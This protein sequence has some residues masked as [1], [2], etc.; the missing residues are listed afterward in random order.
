MAYSLEEIERFTQLYSGNI[1]PLRVVLCSL[2]WVLYDYFETLEDEVRFIWS[3]KRC[4]GKIS[5]LF[6]RYY[7]ILLLVFDV[8]QIH[9]FAIPGITSDAVCLAM[10][11][12]IRMLGAISLWSI[13]VIMQLRVY[14]LFDCSKKVAVFNGVMFIASIIAF[15]V[16]L[17]YN[18]EGR[19]ALIASAV[20]LPLPG[21][22]A[23]NGG[24][25][26]ALWLPA[27]IYETI[28][29]AFVVYKSSRSLTLKVRLG[30]RWSLGAILVGDNML[31]FL[32]ITVLLAFNNV[33]A[34]GAAKIIPWFSYGPFHAAMGI[35]TTR[36]LMHVRKLA[37]Q[38]DAFA[39]LS[40]DDG[41]GEHGEFDGNLPRFVD[42]TPLSVTCGEV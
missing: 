4:V 2:T 18:A 36:M 41:S 14:A 38:T 3:Q 5:Y 22:P 32:G 15:L 21:C 7:T 13:E 34:A 16:L 24:I 26:W 8:A 27:S 42:P 12:T 40:E 28:L 19:A 10:D 1:I 23:I 9:S 20:R 30:E 35:M 39:E 37:A 29:F 17:I 31:Y 25:G 6:M 33:M 11:P